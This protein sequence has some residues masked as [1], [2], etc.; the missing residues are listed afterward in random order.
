MRT[1]HDK[2]CRSGYPA[3]LRRR[4][5]LRQVAAWQRFF[6]F[7]LEKKLEKSGSDVNHLLTFVPLL[8]FLSNGGKQQA[9][10]RSSKWNSVRTTE[11]V[12]ARLARS[13]PGR[14]AHG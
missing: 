1:R 3:R 14:A 8:V 4:D 9:M 6:V 12:A 7:R 11:R 13:G 10:T 5:R 2:A